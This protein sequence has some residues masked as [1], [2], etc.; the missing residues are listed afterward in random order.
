MLRLRY[1][2]GTE[3]HE[4]DRRRLE[5]GRLGSA[6]IPTF[7]EITAKYPALAA[8]ECAYAAGSVVQ[9]W[10]HAAS[11]LDL[12]L[13]TDEPLVPGG[14]LE[15]FVRHVST[16]DPVIR[17]VLGEFGAFRAD[18]ELWRA[19]QIDE[20][21]GRFAGG[22]PSQEAPELD[23]SEQD[24]LYR[25][26]SGSPLHGEGWWAQR[27]EAVLG[28]G[29]GLWLAENR[30]LIAETFLED[31]GGLLRSGDRE[32]AVLAAH[33]AFIGSLEAVF[34]VHGDY[35]INRKWLYRRLQSHPPPEIG[36]D[37]AWAL[38]TMA[39]AADDPAGWAEGTARTAQ[40]LLLSVERGAA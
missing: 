32:S 12:Y 13:V 15:S 36:R 38:L 24:L 4:S 16:A 40:R 37:E 22:T 28:S 19:V 34:A 33:E 6:P 20:I 9:G 17:I 30:K 14:D 7:A 23:K 27:R 31:V 35:S 2:S 1:G 11:D 26:V 21:I 5:A 29:Y 18:I 25:L 3:A 10:G 39:G 8:A